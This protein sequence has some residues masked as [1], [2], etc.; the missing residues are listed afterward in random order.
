MSY[1]FLVFYYGIL[2]NVVNYLFGSLII[3]HIFQPFLY[4]CKTDFRNNNLFVCYCYFVCIC[5]I[6]PS[7]RLLYWMTIK[8]FNQLLIVMYGEGS[9][10][11]GET[12]RERPRPK[13][14]SICCML[15]RGLSITRKCKCENDSS[16]SIAMTCNILLDKNYFR[17][18]PS[19]IVWLTFLWI[20]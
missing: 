4:H 13:D 14:R 12:E 18:V 7:S 1:L 17:W 8:V 3:S 5:S 11:E 6:A 15:L 16:Q 9:E 2:C 10:W 19:T 20:G